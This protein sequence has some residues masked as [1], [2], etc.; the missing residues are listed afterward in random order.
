MKIIDNNSLY[1]GS[2]QFSHITSESAVDIAG[3]N[4]G[5]NVTPAPIIFAEVNE[6]TLVSDFEIDIEITSKVNGAYQPLNEVYLG[7]D[8]KVTLEHSATTFK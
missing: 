2:N 6:K 3:P 7:D 5:S 1:T 4:V 8:I